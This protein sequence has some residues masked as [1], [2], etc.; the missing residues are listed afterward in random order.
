MP[1]FKIYST[2]PPPPNDKKPNHTEKN[3][4]KHNQFATDF[5]EKLK[6][7]PGDLSAVSS[8]VKQHEG[9]VFKA[10]DLS[11]RVCD[12]SGTDYMGQKY[13]LDSWQNLYLPKKTKMEVLGAVDNYFGLQLVV[14]VA[15]D[16]HVFAYEEERMFLL[17][18]SLPE[19]IKNGIDENPKIFEQEKSDE[20]DN[21][22]SDDDLSDD[23]EVQKIRQRTRDFVNSKSE[24]F[25]DMLKFF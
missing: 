10:Q 17:S 16:G 22:L 9:K 18:S 23:D 24:E 8:F 19:L 11:M 2:P 1:E 13:M 12:L 15:E 20:E 4:S 6:Q 14:L 21:D 25:A 3:G 7:N 5:L